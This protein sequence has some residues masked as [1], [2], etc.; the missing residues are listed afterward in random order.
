MIMSSS[1][2]LSSDDRVL[3]FIY[4][5]QG[6]NTNNNKNR[7]I[8]TLWLAFYRTLPR[9]PLDVLSLPHDRVSP[10]F[11]IQ[12]ITVY[13]LRGLLNEMTIGPDG[14]CW[15]NVLGTP[16]LYLRHRQEC[17]M[18]SIRYE[19]VLRVNKLLGFRDAHLFY[20]NYVLTGGGGGGARTGASSSSSL[21]SVYR[22]ERYHKASPMTMDRLFF[23]DLFG[24]YVYLRTLSGDVDAMTYKI[25]KFV[26]ACVFRSDV[27][28]KQLPY[29]VI[30][31]QSEDFEDLA[32]IVNSLKKI[33]PTD[34]VVAAV[35]RKIDVVT[36]A[37]P[38][39]GGRVRFGRLSG[40]KTLL[41][42]AL[43]AF[44][45][46]LE[47]RKRV[48]GSYCRVFTVPIDR[49][50][51]EERKRIICEERCRDYEKFPILL[52]K[53][54]PGYDRIM[55]RHFLNLTYEA[56]NDRPVVAIVKNIV[57]HIRVK[58]KRKMNDDDDDDD[59]DDTTP[60]IRELSKINKPL[61]KN[62]VRYKGI[63]ASFYAKR[64]PAEHI[65]INLN[66]QGSPHKIHGYLCRL[67]NVYDFEQSCFA[68]T[69][70]NVCT[71]SDNAQLAVGN[72]H[73]IRSNLLLGKKMTRKLENFPALIDESKFR[74]T[75]HRED[76]M[77]ARLKGD[78][79]REK[80]RV[81]F[82]SIATQELDIE[83]A[84]MF[85][86]IESRSQALI[87]DVLL[88]VLVLAY[89]CYDVPLSRVMDWM[90]GERRQTVTLMNNRH[91]IAHANEFTLN[92]SYNRHW[93]NR[94]AR[95]LS[96]IKSK[97]YDPINGPPFVKRQAQLKEYEKR[98]SDIGSCFKYSMAKR[99][100]RFNVLDKILTSAD[101]VFY[102]DTTK[103]LLT[104]MKTPGPETNAM[105]QLLLEQH[106]AGRK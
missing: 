100:G 39:K 74:L 64:K 31:G 91:M 43:C 66:V 53:R 58:R 49:F 69:V 60:D 72:V 77:T 13:A 7:D 97:K 47:K 96:S 36:S 2:S 28:Q 88:G 71:T 84:K 87:T 61:A 80:L 94:Q 14:S 106:L 22:T 19:T 30:V 35:E 41:K 52:P 33:W 46:F 18:D 70:S 37:V 79:L 62:I 103:R 56:S 54:K 82:E 27:F 16:F 15:F 63:A 95:S 57:M 8:Q 92:P 48:F 4:R 86:A 40:D 51:I 32:F 25:Y 12:Y 29:E 21:M 89:R 65:T 98:F 104:D 6:W 11:K 5:V 68:P 59:D 26:T 45:A 73:T 20:E 76:S 38:A 10:V 90:S 44:D 42:S 75:M 85:H 83:Q 105:R 50:F 78:E 101:Y 34:V 23:T 99:R 67:A 3:T 9:L 93:S 102:G 55:D 17:E 81:Y 24:W 1:S